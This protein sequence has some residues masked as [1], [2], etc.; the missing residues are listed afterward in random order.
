MKPQNFPLRKERRRLH[1][2]LRTLGAPPALSWKDDTKHRA[3][4]DGAVAAEV[5]RGMTHYLRQEAARALAQTL[6][7]DVLAVWL[8]DAGDMDAVLSRI[9]Q[10]GDD[11]SGFVEEQTAGMDSRAVATFRLDS[12]LLETARAILRCATDAVLFG[13]EMMDVPVYIASPFDEESGWYQMRPIMQR[14]GSR[15]FELVRM[16]LDVGSK[17]LEWAGPV[18]VGGIRLQA[19]RST[20]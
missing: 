7:D 12:D 9:V 5:R 14:T 15:V 19:E 16:R 8:R 2:Q 3:C 18:R 1:A 17:H 4:H 6:T 13:D 20:R 11:P 10:T